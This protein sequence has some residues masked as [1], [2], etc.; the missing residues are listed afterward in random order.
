ME[1]GLLPGVQERCSCEY[2]RFP[3]ALSDGVLALRRP[4]SVQ[5]HRSVM[6]HQSQGASGAAS[7][8]GDADESRDELEPL[9]RCG[10]CRR[11][12]AAYQVSRRKH[13]TPCARYM[14]A[15]IHA[16]VL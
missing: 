11:S 13:L 8:N 1:L 16:N 4:A 10:H 3:G 9:V 15:H 2:H 7:R 5:Q 14:Q 12:A 6:A